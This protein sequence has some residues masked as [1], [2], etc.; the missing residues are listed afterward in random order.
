LLMPLAKLDQRYA[1]RYL[2]EG[3]AERA[4]TAA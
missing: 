2:A 3:N 4:L 1:R